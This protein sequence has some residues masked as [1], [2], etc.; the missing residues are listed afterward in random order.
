MEKNKVGV[1]APNSPYSAEECEEIIAKLEDM[2]DGRL[3]GEEQKAFEEMVTNC[4]FCLEQYR[5][6]KSLRQLIKNGFNNMVMSNKLV[7]NIKSSIRAMRGNLPENT[8]R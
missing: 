1:H 7:A 4:Q 3:T 8:G 6:E 5:I 2:L